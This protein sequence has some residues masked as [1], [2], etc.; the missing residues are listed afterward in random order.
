MPY[1]KIFILSSSNLWEKILNWY[2]NSVIREL[3]DHFEQNVFN[4]HFQGY[5][6]FN[7]SS[8]SAK[9]IKNMIIGLILGMILAS[10]VMC[11]TKA[12]QGKFVRELLRRESFS[13]DTAVTLRDCGFFCNPSVRRELEKGGALSK[14]TRRA[15]V[16]VLEQTA[17]D[18]E[19][20]SEAKAESEALDGVNEGFEAIAYSESVLGDSVFSADTAETNGM[21]LRSATMEL[22][23]AISYIVK[24][25]VDDVI[26]DKKLYAEYTLLGETKSVE[27]EPGDDGRLWATIEGVS[28]KDLGSTL[29]VRPYYLEGNEKVYGAE[30]VYSGYE[31]VRRAQTNSSYSEDVKELARAL[32]VYIDLAYKYGY[33]K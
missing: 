11:Y 7:V 15:D 13:P 27:I 29:K 20:E 24:Y 25:T 17:A 22:K 26:S 30:L 16:G 2:Q 3:L 28:A 19:V 18:P 1:L 8:E 33:N 4:L 12:V 14:I 9:N 23:G 21:R 5:D 6:N 10:A 32:A 31:Y